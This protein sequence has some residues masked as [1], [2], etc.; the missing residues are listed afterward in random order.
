[1]LDTRAVKSLIVLAPSS[2]ESPESRRSKGVK[3]DVSGSCC[4]KLVLGVLVIA[5]DCLGV[6]GYTGLIL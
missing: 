3:M 6:K 5:G 4:D 1:M 2:G